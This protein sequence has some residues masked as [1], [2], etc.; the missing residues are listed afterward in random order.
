MFIQ[1]ILFQIVPRS[2]Q[3]VHAL[4]TS[5]LDYCNSLLYDLPDVRIQRL[6]RIQN[7]ACRIVSRSPKSDHITPLLKELHWL[8][9]ESRIIFKILLLTFKSLNNMAPQ[10]LSDLV[11]FYHPGKNLRSGKQ[12]QLRVP[13]TRLKTYGDR[14]FEFAAAREWNK[15]PLEIKLSPSLSIFKSNIKTHLF[16]LCY[17]EQVFS[18]FC[19]VHHP[20]NF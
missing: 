11:T 16:K 5:R 9:V 7:I 2:A 18:I 8:P 20:Q 4:V 12:L 14:S 10:Y 19:N 13:H 17:K 15:L 3:I 1:I 6:Q